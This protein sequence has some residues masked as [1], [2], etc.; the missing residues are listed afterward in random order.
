MGDTR[1]DNIE[2]IGN[3]RME[4]FSAAHLQLVRDI[5]DLDEDTVRRRLEEAVQTLSADQQG[6]P[7]PPETWRRRVA[8]CMSAAVK[9]QSPHE[10]ASFAPEHL[11]CPITFELIIDPVVTSTGHTYERSAIELIIG[12]KLKAKQ[13]VI[14]IFNAP[15]IALRTCA[16]SPSPSDYTAP[17]FAIKNA[18]GYFKRHNMRFSIL[19]K[20][21][22]RR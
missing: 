12:E 11:T 21:P 15:L 20:A 18:I 10:A 22:Y 13:P 8:L 3:V 1:L 16:A 19:L 2:G 4:L 5:Q 7:V 6:V 14:D 17:N 9:I